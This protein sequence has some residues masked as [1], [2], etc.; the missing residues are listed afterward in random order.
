MNAPPR[1]IP[2]IQTSWARRNQRLKGNRFLGRWGLGHSTSESFT[3]KVSRR[4]IVRISLLQEH[5]LTILY[6]SSKSIQ[7]CRWM[8][9]K[10]K[11]TF[12]GTYLCNSSGSRSIPKLGIL[13]HI[14]WKGKKKESG[15]RN[16][17]H[18]KLHLTLFEFNAFPLG[19]KL[20]HIT[21]LRHSIAFNQ[22][23]RL[24]YKCYFHCV[25]FCRT[26]L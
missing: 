5:T 15:I 6:L 1:E 14:N 18:P 12:N 2:D 7:C 25:V 3:A 26:K 4:R 19:N 13:V 23:N 17:L 8:P 10:F 16:L 11:K 24:T 22:R 20:K 21:I 9:V